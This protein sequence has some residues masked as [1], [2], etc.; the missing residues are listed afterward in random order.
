MA[1]CGLGR[2]DRTRIS[3]SASQT[4]VNALI[5]QSGLPSLAPELVRELDNE[6]ELALLHLRRNRIARVETGEAALWADREA[7]KINIARRVL[8]PSLELVLALHRSRL[9][10]DQAKHDALVPRQQPQRRERAG[11]RRIVFEEVEGDVEHIEQPL[12]DRVVAAF[13]VPLAAPVAAT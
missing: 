2:K 5:A 12:G 8:D 1:K 3:H 13:G 4:R 7:L 9:G 11:A 10:R 6:A